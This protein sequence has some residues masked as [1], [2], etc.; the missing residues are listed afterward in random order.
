[1][2]ASTYLLWIRDVSGISQDKGAK[3]VEVLDCPPPL[4]RRTEALKHIIVARHHRQQ[5]L[6]FDV[7]KN[8]NQCHISADLSHTTVATPPSL[9][10]GSMRRGN[11]KLKPKFDGLTSM[12][13]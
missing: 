12:R 9:A 7:D 5:T 2:T 13:K 6:S 1:M 10:N 3:L 4:V 11:V 8:K